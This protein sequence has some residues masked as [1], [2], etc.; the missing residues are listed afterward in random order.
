MKYVLVDSNDVI[1]TSVELG[2]E[3]GKSGARTYF[4]GTKRLKEKEFDKLWRVMTKKEYDRQS[5]P[6][7]IEWWKDERTNPDMEK[8]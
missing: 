6:G 4:V 1:N 8:D 5:H 3:V 7:Y 2:S